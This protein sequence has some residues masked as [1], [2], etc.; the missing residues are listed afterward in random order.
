MDNAIAQRI[1]FGFGLSLLVMSVALSARPKTQVNPGTIVGRAEP[2]S[3]A[4]AGTLL[5]LLPQAREVREEGMDV[6]WD[7]VTAPERKSTDFYEFW[8][9]KGSDLIGFFSVNIH[10]GDVWQDTAM[11]VRDPELATAQDV[12]REAHHIDDLTI[13]RFQG[14]KPSVLTMGDYFL[15]WVGR[16]TP[17]P[18]DDEMRANFLQHRS[19]FETLLK[20]ADDDKHVVRIDPDF[21]SL[22]TDS[23]WPR[24]DIGFSEER[25]KTYRE[26][27]WKLKIP[28]GIIRRG[29]YPSAVFFQASSRGIFNNG[30]AKGYVYSIYSLSP[31][32]RSLDDI[33]R[34]STDAIYFEAIAP[35][36]YIFFENEQ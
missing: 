20:M 28:D 16:T 11:L 6:S 19:D 33:P 25:W 13:K 4:D 29:D 2:L 7:P 35:N 10:T 23:S 32:R 15:L 5:H 14:L 36:W 18:S 3:M 9:T 26:M 30:S 22:D 34:T 31:M 24:T 8:V 21:T 17:H 27:F 12:L 1:G